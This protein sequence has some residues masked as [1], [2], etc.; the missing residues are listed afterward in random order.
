MADSRFFKRKGP[1]SVQEIAELTGA[2]LVNAP[3][4]SRRF[5]DVSPL[6]NAD[7]S[8]LSFFDNRKYLDAFVSSS[9]GG[10]FVLPI[11]CCS[12]P[13][14]RTGHMPRRQRHIIRLTPPMVL[15]HR[16]R[17]SPIPP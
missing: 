2:E 8:I 1:F 14:I 5:D 4:P 13:A 16:T 7:A 3:D 11:W 6:Q 12:R 15:F 9:A 10:C 17:L